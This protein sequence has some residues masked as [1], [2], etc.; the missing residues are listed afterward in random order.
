MTL[1][2]GELRYLFWLQVGEDCFDFHVDHLARRAES[3]RRGGITRGSVP[4]S[5]AMQAARRSLAEAGGT[6]E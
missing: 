2:E 6:H 5:I 1:N 3:A 4:R